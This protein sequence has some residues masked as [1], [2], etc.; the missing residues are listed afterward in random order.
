MSQIQLLYQLQQV[1]SEIQE[2]K[3]QLGAVLQAQKET[4]VLLRARGRLKTAV[5]ILSSSQA[6]QKTLRQEMD[7]LDRNK[8]SAEQRLY[9]GNIKNPKELG[10]L[11]DKIESLGR[12]RTVLEDDMLDLMIA[13]DEGEEEQVAATSHLEETEAAWKDDQAALKKEQHTLALRLH[14]LGQEREQKLPLIEAALLKR[15][16]NIITRK[17]GLAVVRL[18][19]DRCSGCQLNVYAQSVKKVS[20]GEIVECHNCGRLLAP[21]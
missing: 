14:K 12:R 7:V 3:G 1:D 4:D 10:D 11:Q 5:S 16:D 20:E 19:G 13:V 17:K 8:K 18:R 2:K 21:M 9:S 15:Y 6:A